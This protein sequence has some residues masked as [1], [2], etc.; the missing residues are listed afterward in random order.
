MTPSACNESQRLSN[1]QLH[2][3]N[4]ADVQELQTILESAPGY[5]LVIQGKPAGSEAAVEL[6]DDLPRGKDAKDK[7][8]LALYERSSST[9]VGCVEL[10]PGFP[11][12]D[13]AYL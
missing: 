2:R 11:N 7:L 10:I 3:A 1:R 8:V 4:V 5:W 13:I 6:F 12:D 9:A